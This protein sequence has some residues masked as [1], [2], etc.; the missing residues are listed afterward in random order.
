MSP[1]LAVQSSSSPSSSKG[2]SKPAPRAES[3]HAQP[4]TRRTRVVR[5]RGRGRLD[6]LESDEEIER[7]A[8]SDASDSDEPSL[9]DSASDSEPESDAESAILR[10]RRRRSDTP[11]T[12]QSPPPGEVEAAA[13]LDG[14]TIAKPDLGTVAHEPPH[15]APAFLSTGMHWSDMVADES[16]GISGAGALPVID[17][18]DLHVHVGVDSE[19]SP[20]VKLSGASENFPPDHEREE[21]AGSQQGTERPHRARSIASERPA[22]GQSARQAYQHRLQ[23]DPQ[24][25]PTVGEFWGH[26]DRLMQKDLRSLSGWWRG[27]WQGRARGRGGFSSRGMRGRGRGGNFGGPGHFLQDGEDTA[28]AVTS[29]HTE[30]GPALEPTLPPIEKAWTHDGFEEMKARD[31]R[32]QTS[33]QQRATRPAVQPGGRGGFVNRGRGSPTQQR[34][35]FSSSLRG[36]AGASFL[37]RAQPDRTWF[38]MKPER[39]WTKQFEGFLYLDPTLKPKPGR[40]AGFRVSLPGKGTEVIRASAPVA[41]EEPAALRSQAPSEATDAGAG[42]RIVVKVPKRADKENMEKVEAP[43]VQPE[44][45]TTVEES[46]V[47]V[48]PVDRSS[49]PAWL[50]VSPAENVPSVSTA[51]LSQPASPHYHIQNGVAATPSLT[52]YSSLS[53]KSTV[54]IASITAPTSALSLETEKGRVESI[55]AEPMLPM[56]PA[57]SPPAQPSP[58]YGSPYAF[59]PTLPPGI[60]LNQQGFA[61]EAPSSTP[62]LNGI[63]DPA[64]GQPIFSL[65]RQSSRIEIR[66]PTDAQEGKGKSERRPSNLRSTTVAEH[67]QSESTYTRSHPQPPLAAP[68]GLA[69]YASAP[70]FFPSPVDMSASVTGPGSQHAY[71]ASEGTASL[72]PGHEERPPAVPPAVDLGMIGYAG[73]QQQYYYPEQYYP[74]YVEMPPQPGQYDPYGVDPLHQ[75]PIYY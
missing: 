25:V 11:S 48:I 6:G 28:E 63:V 65:P 8:M 31:E 46:S 50:P 55:P 17:F 16:A 72:S 20:A 36:R 68:L 21:D 60:A 64:T 12:T 9:V 51:V 33:E 58:T 38:A 71:H 44:S 61:F 66:A 19:L 29:Q 5:R 14:F 42:K 10:N 23:T 4:R 3:A 74:A 67:S 1:A 32:R 27:R 45:V 62:P 30:D 70:E 26:D 59:A 15:S 13:A 53:D 49:S 43:E 54:D 73:Y 39:I 7:D 22:P 47:P 35:A 41:Q 34:G 18:A 56:Q 2:A 57:F 69:R 40:P 24:F 52:R 37:N 75:P